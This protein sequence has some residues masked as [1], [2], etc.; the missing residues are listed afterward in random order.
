M[1]GPLGC[2]GRWHE[3]LS[4]CNIVVVYQPAEDNDVAN[5]M[6]RWAYPA[7]LADDTNFYGSN[8]DL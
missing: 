1:A 4:R 3:F 2:R 5:R 7:G 8:A 6:S